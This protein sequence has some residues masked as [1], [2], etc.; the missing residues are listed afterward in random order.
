M[1]A[2][3]AG[4]AAHVPALLQ[5]RSGLARAAATVAGGP[6][7]AAATEGASSRTNAKGCVRRRGRHGAA[8]ATEP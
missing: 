3:R 2:F 5:V 4:A 7:A 1:A 8:L 6:S